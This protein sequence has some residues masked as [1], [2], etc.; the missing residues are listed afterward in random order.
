MESDKI[1]RM[2][3][4][5]P[6]VPEQ[7][8]STTI[9]ARQREKRLNAYRAD[10]SLIR[11]AF[12]GEE[13]QRREY[14]QR[15]ILELL[16][17][18]EDALSESDAGRSGGVLFDL[19]D[20]RLIVA[21]HGAPFSDA[22]FQA[23]CNLNDS[24]KPEEHR[25]DCKR[26]M[27]GSKGTGFKAVLNWADRIE[28]FSGGIAALFDRPEAARLIRNRLGDQGC[29]D[30]DSKGHW[31]DDK[32]P[33]LQVPLDAERDARIG[34]LEDEDW[35]TIF[36]LRIRAEQAAEVAKA[37][38]H[39]DPSRFLFLDRLD[40]VQVAV[41]GQSA[42]WS[43]CRT[44]RQAPV[45]GTRC[46]LLQIRQNDAPVAE[47]QVVKRA[48]PQLRPAK[49]A[50]I[51]EAEIGFA[52]QVDGIYDEADGASDRVSNF[53]A[54]DCRSPLQ[55]IA[56]HGTFL[57]KAD[58]SRLAED[59]LPY[60][61]GLIK[62]L[63]ALL[64]E[65]VIP[66]LV[67]QDGSGALNYLIPTNP[68]ESGVHREIHDSLIA[69]LRSA[70]FVP[71]IGGSVGAPSELRTWSH[72][73]GE[74]LLK[75]KAPVERQDLP[76]PHWC[77]DQARG[78]LRKLGAT[79]LSPSAYASALSGFQPDN[80]DDAC[81]AHAL[82]A[83][84]YRDIDWR[85]FKDTYTRRQEQESFQEITKSLKIWQG[86]DGRWRS[87]ANE[88]PLFQGSQQALE[89]PKIIRCDCLAT[90]FQKALKAKEVDGNRKIWDFELISAFR[91]PGSD[92]Q[93]LLHELK[94]D[95]LIKYALLPA[96]QSDAAW[97]R[98]NGRDVLQALQAIGCQADE[99]SDVLNDE[100][101]VTL[102]QRIR[103]PTQG[104]DWQPAGQVYAGA[105]WDNPW[106]EAFV[107]KT[108]GT[109]FIL[110]RPE[111]LP[112]G[113]HLAPILGYIGVSWQ[114]K[115]IKHSKQDYDKD[116]Y[117]WLNE[118]TMLPADSLADL[119]WPRYWAD[120]GRSYLEKDHCDKGKP[121]VANWAVLSAWGIEGIADYVSAFRDVAERVQA[122][123]GLW[124]IVQ[125]PGRDIK[126]AGRGPQGKR[127][128][129]STLGDIQSFLAWQIQHARVFRIEDSPLFPR[130]EA[131]FADILIDSQPRSDWRKW[132]PR[133]DLHK[134]DAQ[135]RR[136]LEG[137]AI[138]F[139]AKEK[140]KDFDQNQWLAW[141]SALSEAQLTDADA[142]TVESF[143]HALSR[144]KWEPPPFASKRRLPC[145]FRET[146]L[147][148]CSP[149][150][151]VIIDDPRF[152]PLRQTLLDSGQAVLLGGEIE[153][154][155]LG[156]LLGCDQR[157][158]SKLAVIKVVSDTPCRQGEERLHLAQR[159][160]PLV[161][162]WVEYAVG[163]SAANRLNMHWPELVHVH[164]PLKVAVTLEG[165][166]LE[167]DAALDFH[168]EPGRPLFISGSD[169]LWD[170][171][172]A[173]LKQVAGSQGDFV[174]GLVRLLEAVES[175][176]QLT[177]G[178]AFL[179]QS[180]LSEQAWKRWEKSDV[181]VP[182]HPQAEATP[183]TAAGGG[184]EAPVTTVPESATAPEGA[185]EPGPERSEAGHSELAPAAG[186]TTDSEHEPARDQ[187]TPPDADAVPTP[188]RAPPPPKSPSPSTDR[189]PGVTMGAPGEPPVYPRRPDATPPPSTPVEVPV[190]RPA[191]PPAIP[192]VD[193]PGGNAPPMRKPG[194]IRPGPGSPVTQPGPSPP[195]TPDAHERGRKAEEWFLL[196]L[197]KMIGS[198]Y[199]IK[200]HDRQGGGETDLVVRL[201]GKDVLDIEVK[202]MGRS[203]FYWSANEVMKA[204]TR[205]SAKIPYVLAIL[206]PDDATEEG[207]APWR[208]R[209]IT[210]PT[211]QL[212][213]RW[214]AGGVKGEWRWQGH[215]PVNADK[216][217]TRQPWQR[218]GAPSKKAK[219]ISFIV[220]PQEEDFDAEGLKYV[221]ALLGP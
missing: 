24:G 89:L 91:N 159:A 108:P 140:L 36:R 196:Q 176:G 141:L 111:E 216:L 104:G 80:V 2:G 214:R 211:R 5:H 66:A 93:P 134:R 34:E 185:A 157:R 188:D 35:Q 23:L 210:D 113:M 60:Q 206:I 17:N 21:N 77:D 37:L 97:W 147:A 149:D 144:Q 27:I 59:D 62:A 179:V 1:N 121:K 202:H 4:R 124:M 120:V 10:P 103:V 139:G 192:E 117:G 137:F 92:Q 64:G 160:R 88:T 30:L 99:G 127:V 58:R 94:P 129:D 152:A 57:L 201:A 199:E 33:L 151:L 198:Q 31:P 25:Q 154:A 166:E 101:R 190:H 76:H 174:H 112:G 50:E 7:L 18:V 63:C 172:A 173:G 68:P 182:T 194:G 106:A 148:F 208:V 177:D 9:V 54:T 186:G 95:A 82:L 164:S 44:G 90:T 132:L 32:M 130:G 215:Q 138:A 114:P 38:H 39:I 56:V 128:F 87:I 6:M 181:P 219:G 67:Q 168:W 100:L 213:A 110:A 49:E 55:A 187:A 163:E 45:P 71:T 155:A 48:L 98:Q 61:R 193:G 209:W 84:A 171:L 150:S 183:P 8:S 126:I 16:Q 19:S 200:Q 178:E 15:P 78:I 3:L 12:N 162:A 116:R 79:D 184:D 70:R 217:K 29:V 156:Q 143:L 47:Y 125:R 165:S 197:K 221:S 191:A 131:S 102:S 86:Q 20:Q 135:E 73:L 13:A 207:E 153:S 146:R 40:Q 158:F 195:W 81:Q 189:P 109:R 169:R 53:F 122:L 75:R 161:L 204:Q 42:Q 22:G 83:A 51:G 14:L 28:L 69:A 205:A 167:S 220:T 119:D 74:L 133:L 46:Y 41:D 180:G 212:V 85:R 136:R 26:R 170:R 52:W 72:G 105:A 96:V 65:V 11:S 218:P 142:K 123:S 118:F 107:K 175:T 115:W 145:Q 203:E 43:L